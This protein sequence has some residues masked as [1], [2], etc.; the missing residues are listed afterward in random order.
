MR[1]KE[2]TRILDTI[3]DL[4]GWLLEIIVI[5]IMGIAI[6]KTFQYLMHLD[7]ENT[8]EEFLFLLILLEIY[9]LISLYLKYHHVSM[10][11]VV[12]LGVI[13]IVR[14][15]MIVKDYN[16]LNPFTLIGLG[17]V[18]V[19]LGWIYVNLRESGQQE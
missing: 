4:V 19:A 10:R 2:L 8:L 12:E 13:A 11:R 3:F 18:I 1:G 7:L 15:L 5:G 17:L 9:E 16:S 14:K 6:F